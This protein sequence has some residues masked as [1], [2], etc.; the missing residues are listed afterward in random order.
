MM[1]LVLLKLLVLLPESELVNES[2]VL[3]A[4][5]FSSCE[6]LEWPH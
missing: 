4:Y 2:V 1:V 3:F 5:M 6:Q